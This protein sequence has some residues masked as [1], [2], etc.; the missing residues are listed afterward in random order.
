MTSIALSLLLI[1]VLT[2]RTTNAI[3]CHVMSGGQTLAP[4]DC[5]SP[6]KL[7]VAFIS[8]GKITKKATVF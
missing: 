6:G 5:A 3:K 8:V 4:I 7:F 1:A 2:A